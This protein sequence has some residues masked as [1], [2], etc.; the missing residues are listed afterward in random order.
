MT[1]NDLRYKAAGVLNAKTLTRSL[2]NAHWRVRM[3]HAECS[4][5]ASSIVWVRRKEGHSPRNLGHFRRG[6]L[7]ASF[8]HRNLEVGLGASINHNSLVLKWDLAGER[9]LPALYVDYKNLRAILSF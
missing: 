9:K 8:S 4:A 3:W 2:H 1:Y 6:F 5:C 7:F